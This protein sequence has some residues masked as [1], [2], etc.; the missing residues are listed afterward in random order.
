MVDA[1]IIV[2][3]HCACKREL[4]GWLA[5]L[6]RIHV[7]CLFSS[8]WVTED[9]KSKCFPN[10]SKNP[11]KLSLCSMS[12]AKYDKAKY[13]DQYTMT[14]IPLF[15]HVFQPFVFIWS[16]LSNLNELGL[17]NCYICHYILWIVCLIANFHQYVNQAYNDVYCIVCVQG[18][19]LF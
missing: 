11:C 7:K 10:C 16:C 13:H 4:I 14:G 1:N 6:T 19:R 17:I 5:F 2:S 3:F 12:V 15:G 18:M 8:R 9:K